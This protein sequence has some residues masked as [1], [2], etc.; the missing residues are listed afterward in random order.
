[1]QRAIE[2]LH[3]SEIVRHRRGPRIE[4]PQQEQ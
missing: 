3:V 2:R 4:M 1:M